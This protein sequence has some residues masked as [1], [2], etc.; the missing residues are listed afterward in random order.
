MPDATDA[1]GS[2]SIW[3]NTPCH[4]KNWDGRQSSIEANSSQGFE[5]EGSVEGA[6]VEELLGCPPKMLIVPN[7]GMR[8]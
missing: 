5:E 6:K 8:V 1:F 3:S 2:S 7:Q 4:T